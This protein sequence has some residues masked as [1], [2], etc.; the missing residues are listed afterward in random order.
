MKVVRIGLSKGINIK[1]NNKN[2]IKLETT[3]QRTWGRILLRKKENI[4]ST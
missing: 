1:L 2:Q 3:K 4:Q